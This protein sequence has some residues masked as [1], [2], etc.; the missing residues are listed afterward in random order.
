[1]DGGR[2]LAL[3]AGHGLALQPRHQIAAWI[4]QALALCLALSG[5][6]QPHAHLH[7]PSSFSWAHNRKPPWR[8]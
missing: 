1:M 3:G 5:C 4:G 6:H 2:V 7:L 8:R